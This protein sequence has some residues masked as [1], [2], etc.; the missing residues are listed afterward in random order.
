MVRGAASLDLAGNER[1]GEQKLRPRLTW[2]TAGHERLERLSSEGP[3]FLSSGT[4]AS[5]V[6]IPVAV[7]EILSAG[8]PHRLA[9]LTRRPVA[10]EA[11]TTTLTAVAGGM[12]VDIPMPMTVAVAIATAHPR[13]VPVSTEPAGATLRHV[14]RGEVRN[15]ASVL[16]PLRSRQGCANQ[17]PMHR[18]VN[19]RGIAVRRI[20][21]F[22]VLRLGF[23]RRG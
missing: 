4:T 17:R 15:R 11:R 20:G 9:I 6:A 2:E 16:L 21:L 3:G 8:A 13:A 10:L 12:A 14:P 1:G 19:D 5:L 18:P 23:Y 22:S 7:A